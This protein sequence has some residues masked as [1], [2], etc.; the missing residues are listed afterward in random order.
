M[1]IFVVFAGGGVQGIPLTGGLQAIESSEYRFRGFGGSSMGAIIA[2]FAALG[3]RA[4]Q[5]IQRLVSTFVHDR[6]LAVGMHAYE[7]ALNAIRKRGSDGALVPIRWPKGKFG[8]IESIGFAKRAHDL[9]NDHRLHTVAKNAG[10]MSPSVLRAALERALIAEQPNTD[11]SLDRLSWRDFENRG[12]LLR[13]VATDLVTRRA[14]V[15]PTDDPTIGVLDAVTASAAYPLAFSPVI[16]GNRVLVDGGIS[17]NVPAFIFNNEAKSAYGRTFV[18]SLT[19]NDASPPDDLLGY[20]AASAR[21]AL[22]AGDALLPSLL[23]RLVQV[24]IPASPGLPIIGAADGSQAGRDQL[25]VKIHNACS[26]ARTHALVEIGR[27]PIILKAHDRNLSFREQRA[28]EYK[29]LDEW[30]ALFLAI[31]SQVATAHLYRAAAP[32]YA[33]FLSASIRTRCG[34]FVPEKGRNWEKWQIVHSAGFDNQVVPPLHG[35]LNVEL[36]VSDPGVGEAI[37]SKD[38][39]YFNPKE[40][41]DGAPP[42]S[43][44]ARIPPCRLGAVALPIFHERE[45]WLDEPDDRPDPIA[46]L[47]VDAALDLD[48]LRASTATPEFPDGALNDFLLAASRTASRILGG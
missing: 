42:D 43:E 14:C 21:S 22:A 9:W 34:L 23:R 35:D 31:R 27:D 17:T 39:I 4:D 7:Q 32:T 30:N 24:K 44:A 1:Q 48:E 25:A 36:R 26:D 46:V 19:E 13:V 45:V 15:F 33:D 2:L 29:P 47:L 18:F 20:L 41:R 37:R 38:I 3:L 40:I 6:D 11:I 8:P 12:V 28:A 5:I 10:F 16:H